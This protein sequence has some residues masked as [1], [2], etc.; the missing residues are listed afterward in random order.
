[1]ACGSW[2]ARDGRGNKWV[3]AGLLCLALLVVPAFAWLVAP[4]AGGFAPPPADTHAA[5]APDPPPAAEPPPEPN[6]PAPA[7]RPAVVDR[8]AADERTDDDAESE[9][10]NGKVLDPDGKP[11]A[12]AVVRCVDKT[13]PPL[14]SMTDGAGS[15]RLPLAADGCHAKARHGEWAPSDEVLVAKGQRNEIRMREGGSVE[16]NVVDEHGVGV[17]PVMVAVESFVAATEPEGAPGPSG[18]AKHFD[19][20]S[21]EFRL[22]K[23]APGRYVLTASAEGRPPA[24]S[25]PF[26][27][28]AGRTARGVKI[29]LP[30]GGRLTGHVVDAETKK[31]IGGAIV[32]LDSMTTSQA[33]AIK[34]VTTDD[35]GAFTLDGAPPGPFSIRVGH[36]EYRTKIVPGLASGAAPTSV[37]VELAPRGDGGNETEMAGIGAHILPANGLLKVLFVEP[38]GP[39]AKAGLAALDTILAI[40]GVPIDAMTMMDCT[41][42]LRGPAGTKVVVTVDRGEP[43]DIAITR[44]NL[45]LGR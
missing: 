30:K 40:D 19:S 33:N 28:E 32:S 14:F 41:Q 37:E 25:E 39:A 27:V 34:P 9:G 26:Q 7:A 23:L 18:R 5:A 6:E 4:R 1:M 11:V 31:P 45:R 2:D 12:R 42:R 20:R 24:H 38:D 22:E 3:S 43:M 16:G 44:D 10:I 13:D 36:L 29:V 8:P 17:A 21:G 35:A 15:F